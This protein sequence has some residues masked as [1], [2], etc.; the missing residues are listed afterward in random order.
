MCGRRVGWFS[1]NRALLAFKQATWFALSHYE[2]LRVR[3]S[4]IAASRFEGV[5]ANE[6]S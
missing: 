1:C 4:T 6:S 5:D 2:K 3:T